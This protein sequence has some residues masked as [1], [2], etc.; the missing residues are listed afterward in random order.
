MEDARFDALL[1]RAADQATRREAVGVLLGGALLYGTANAGEAT[2]RAQRRKR[3]K[4]NAKS[5]GIVRGIS[6]IIDNTAGTHTIHVE[7]GE[8]HST[9]CCDLLAVF[10]I[11]PGESRLF[12]TSAAQAYAWVNDHSWFEFDNPLIGRPDIS[13]ARDGMM[14][15]ASCCK[16]QGQTL[17]HREPMNE[18]ETITITPNNY[19][20]Y[21]VTRN[22][23]KPDFKFFT[24]K[25][26][27]EL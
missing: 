10:N 6:F 19:T 3:Q 21:K 24:L 15:G 18:G 22:A 26:P 20:Y 2:K 7:A 27:K 11:A 17:L 25:L 5:R 8:V 16:P 1:R 12:D 4:R 23:D 9:R 14:G 13:Y